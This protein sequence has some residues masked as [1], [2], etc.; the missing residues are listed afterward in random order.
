MD[1]TSHRPP[2]AE[3]TDGQPAASALRE[4]DELQKGL[5]STV[6]GWPWNYPERANSPGSEVEAC[7]LGR[8]HLFL[9]AELRKTASAPSLLRLDLLSTDNKV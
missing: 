5:G 3:V 8:S 4:L 1:G 9:R 6:I 7:G 2:M